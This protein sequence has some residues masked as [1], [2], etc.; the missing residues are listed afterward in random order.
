MA[1]RCAERAEARRLEKEYLVR[2]GGVLPSDLSALKKLFVEKCPRAAMMQTGPDKECVYRPLSKLLGLIDPYV[3]G[4]QVMVGIVRVDLDEVFLENSELG[5]L[6]WDVLKQLLIERKVAMPN[7]VV[8]RDCFLET[9][10]YQ[11]PHL[12]WLL[13]DSV[14]FTP[15]GWMKFKG[16]LAQVIRGII[17]ALL[18]IGA[19]PGAMSNSCKT[20]NPLSPAWT[21][22]EFADEPYSLDEIAATVDTTITKRKLLKLHV[23]ARPVKS[24]PVPDHEDPVIA[25]M[26]NAVHLHMTS[27]AQRAVNQFR[28]TST[29]G[30][31]FDY[32]HAEAQRV[33]KDEMSALKKA[34][35]VASWTWTHWRG[36]VEG[37]TMEPEARRASHI[38]RVQNVA[39]KRSMGTVQKL[40][41]A[42]KRLVAELGRMPL[43]P[44]VAFAAG[45]SERTLERHKTV[46]TEMQLREQVQ[47]AIFDHRIR[48][49]ISDIQNAVVKKGLLN[50]E[51]QKAASHLP[52]TP[53]GCSCDSVAD[54]VPISPPSPGRR[55]PFHT[56]PSF[57][58]GSPGMAPSPPFSNRPLSPTLP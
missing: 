39:G 2:C 58:S 49:Q 7:F 25:G 35:Y 36:R 23:A 37:V 47:A 45:V 55:H 6:G 21:T 4:N 40:I 9:R 50:S 34:Q 32:V 12:I 51:N 24:D 16:K 33:C 3:T 14:C 53:T 54:V 41:D 46:M 31:F 8:G 15:N 1:E 5:L 44:E 10:E 52:S 42:E 56:R 28:E 17:A 11:R 29:E 48:Q 18:D 22:K 38:A 13:R 30:A 43:R 27:C 19:D 57:M 20:K 26:S